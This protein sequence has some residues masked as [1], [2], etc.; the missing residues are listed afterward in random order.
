[1]L[2]AFSKETQYRLFWLLHAILGFVLLL[3]SASATSFA[4]F[5]AAV[6]LLTIWVFFSKARLYL[7]IFLPIVVILSFASVPVMK[8]YVMPVFLS[9]FQKDMSLTG[10]TDVWDAALKVFLKKPILGYG[11][12][13][14]WMGQGGEGRTPILL[15]T[16]KVPPHAHNQWLETAIGMGIVGLLITGFLMLSALIR[17]A[18]ISA[19]EEGDSMRHYGL[20]VVFAVTFMGFA[21]VPLFVFNITTFIVVLNY[22]S[23][24]FMKTKEENA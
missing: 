14:F 24:S 18:K 2:K 8:N 11:H 17:A 4:A 15:E 23:S 16:E 10:R 5:A 9:S 1:M 6:L 22:L 12:G 20:F 3:F 7:L 21:E 19:A 13:A